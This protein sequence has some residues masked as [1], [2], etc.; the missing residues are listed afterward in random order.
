MPE[1]FSDGHVRITSG[2]RDNALEVIRNAAAD[3]RLDFDEHEARVADVMRAT[4]RGELAAV[5]NDLVGAADLPE[6]VADSAPA[7][8]GPGFRHEHPLVLRNTSYS[9]MHV[10]GPWQVPPFV[11]LVSAKGPFRVDLT[12]AIPLAPVIDIAVSMH[13][14]MTSLWLGVPEGWGVDVREATPSSELGSLSSD[15][16]SRPSPGRPKVVLR[17]SAGGGLVVRHPHDRDLRK[18]AR[19]LGSGKGQPPALSS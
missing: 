6:I 1:A 15:V 8:E 5:L 3:A 17:G 16:P 18:T 14:W 9:T 11:E 13:S 19:L 10:A 2:Q 4:T 7:G 12:Q